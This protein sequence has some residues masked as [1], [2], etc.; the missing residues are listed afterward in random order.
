MGFCLEVAGEIISNIEDD[1]QEIGSNTGSSTSSSK[2]QNFF[3]M[4][5][6]K[7]Y[8]QLKIIQYLSR[9]FMPLFTLVFTF[10]YIIV[11]VY[12]Y[13]NPVLKYGQDWIG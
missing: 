2:K 3:S 8:I 11:C 10:V 4:K 7:I 9:Y 13:N 6:K 12:N 5:E 1:V